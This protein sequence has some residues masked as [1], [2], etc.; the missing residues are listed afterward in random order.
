MSLGGKLRTHGKA[1]ALGVLA[2]AGATGAVAYSRRPVEVAVARVELGDVELD[3]VGTGTLESE[4]VVALAFTVPGRIQ[5]LEVSEGAVVRTGQVLGR[6]DV[7]TVERERAVASAG[8]AVAALGVTRA[9]ADIARAQARVESAETDAARVRALVAADVATRAELDA[10]LERQ[11]VARAELAAARASRSQGGASVSVARETAALYERRV[12][13]GVLESPLDGVVVARR[14]E[15]GDVVGAGATVL[16]VAATEKLWARVWVDEAVLGDLAPGAEA[17][18][19]RR[20]SGA[21]PLAARVDRVAPEADRRTHEVLVDLELLE[22]PGRFAFGQRVDARITLARRAD[23]RRVLRS[24]CDPAGERCLVE[25]NGEL[26]WAEVSVGLHGSD[27][28]EIVDGLEV[29][30]EVVDRSSFA[31]APPVGRRVRRSAP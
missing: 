16:S 24:A 28:L 8:V 4:A 27:H 9:D 3:A 31:G 18:V 22:R 5:A 12:A 1:L 29:G 14:H 2:L 15:P 11:A 13:D 30:D 21:P 10:A 25:R 26:A 19:T 20:G 6:L 7:A 23:V 17:R